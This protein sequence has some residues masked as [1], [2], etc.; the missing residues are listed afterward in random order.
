MDGWIDGR[1]DRD[2]EGGGRGGIV[3]EERGL[4]GVRNRIK[5]LKQ[6]KGVEVGKGRRQVQ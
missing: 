6:G 1:T 2:W 4:L 3:R 5:S